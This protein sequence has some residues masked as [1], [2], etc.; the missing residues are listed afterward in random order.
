M[1]D[2]VPT[3]QPLPS[4]VRAMYNAHPFP[5]R[6]ISSISE[7]DKRF[8]SIF[9]DFLRIPLSDLKGK[10]LLDAGCGTG[11]NTWTW[12]RVLDP[13]TRMVAVDLSTASVRRAQ[14]NGGGFSP[15]PLFSVNS[16]L[17]LGL[18]E[19][20]VDVV[21]CSGVLVA[22]ADP[23]RAFRELTRVLKPGGYMIIVLYHRYGRALHSLRRGVIDL[24]EKE[25]VD[26]RARLG[27][28]LFEGPMRRLAAQDQV[29]YEELLYD[30][31][32]LP[33]ESV[34]S[35]GK[36]LRWF[37][38]ANVDYLGTFPAIEWSRFGQALR[39]SHAV[40]KRPNSVLV[41]LLLKAFP[42]TQAVPGR[43]PNWFTRTTMQT[44]WA[45]NQLQLFAI[46]GRKRA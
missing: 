12:R 41:R 3:K 27:G 36:A 25:D 30:Q 9:R 31:F 10:T 35:V 19:H 20:G 17:D 18:A 2:S 15:Q 11:E 43:A 44:V 28:K 23:E 38:Q 40:A 21:Y 1:S 5:Q 14:G 6:T 45:L 37:K 13:S 29:P 24:I 46:S 39:F 32:G 4:R 8:A 42:D 22:V 7:N 34:Y 33:C 26:R 16:L